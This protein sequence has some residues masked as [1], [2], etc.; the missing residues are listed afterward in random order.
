MRE[1]ETKKRRLSRWQQTLPV[2]GLQQPLLIPPLPRETVEEDAQG[3]PAPVQLVPLLQR[4]KGQPSQA[5]KDPH[6]AE[7]LRLRRLRRGLHSAEPADQ[8]PRA[9]AQMR[10]LPATVH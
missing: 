10:H 5:R 3:D 8:A 7:A 2:L 9:A 6:G 4:Q 1:K